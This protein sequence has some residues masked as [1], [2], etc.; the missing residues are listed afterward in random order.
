M[1]TQGRSSTAIRT[2]SIAGFAAA[3]TTY[4]MAGSTSPDVATAGSTSGASGASGST[5]SPRGNG[6]NADG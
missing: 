6:N 2:A 1:P 3:G 4:W 5:G